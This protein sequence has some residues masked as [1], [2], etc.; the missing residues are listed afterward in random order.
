MLNIASFEI[1]KI[2]EGKTSIIDVATFR[3]VSK[4]ERIK[5]YYSR[6]LSPVWTRW[7]W[8]REEAI[9]PSWWWRCSQTLW[10][11]TLMTPWSSSHSW[12]TTDCCWGDLTAWRSG[13]AVF[14]PARAVTTRAMKTETIGDNYQSMG[15][16][17]IYPEVAV[18]MKM[19]RS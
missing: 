1:D 17:R 12:Y 16:S 15:P 5:T 18:I 8:R 9:S 13:T 7:P 4:G 2:N 10:G 3:I 11:I 6:Y 19:P 14:W